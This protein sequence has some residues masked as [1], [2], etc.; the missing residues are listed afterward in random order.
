[1]AGGLAGGVHRGDEGKI[2][3]VRVVLSS[4]A[5]R[6]SSLHC[7]FLV[8]FAGGSNDGDA[9]WMAIGGDVG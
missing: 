6:S 2:G 1:M 5:L 4:A 8:L 9:S 3:G 7:C